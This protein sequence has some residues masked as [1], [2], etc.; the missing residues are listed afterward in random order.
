MRLPIILLCALGLAAC[1]PAI[2]GVSA[3]LGAASIAVTY[4]VTGDEPAPCD[5][6]AQD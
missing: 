4:E 6:G 5:A 1:T 3:A 2:I